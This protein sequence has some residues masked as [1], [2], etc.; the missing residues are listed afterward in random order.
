MWTILIS[1]VCGGLI[2]AAI[3]GTRKLHKIRRL[4][5]QNKMLVERNEACAKEL[6]EKYAEITRER[7]KTRDLRRDLALWECMANEIIKHPTP[8]GE[9]VMKNV[10][11]TGVQLLK[12][13]KLEL[14]KS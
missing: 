4:K 5:G 6:M 12:Y 7:D 14:N 10:P 3:S 2:G 13:Y 9:P 8:P 11:E 1:A